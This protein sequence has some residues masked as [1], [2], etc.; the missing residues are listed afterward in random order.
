MQKLRLRAWLMALVLGLLAATHSG[1]AQIENQA[2]SSLRVLVLDPAG[3]TI[4]GAQ[5][6]LIQGR[7][8][9]GTLSTNQLGE[10]VF[11]RLKPAQ[12]RVYVE[13]DGFEPREVLQVR[14]RSGANQIEVRLDVK[15]IKDDVEVAIDKREALTDPGLIGFTN[16]LT[17]EQIALLP[18]DPEEFEA[19]LR[20]MAGPGATFRV[21]GF[22]GGRLP[23]K[24]QI[25]EIRF[26]LN[27]YT[28]ENHEP[29]LIS[30]DIFTKPGMDLWH[31]SLSI[32]SMPAM[33]S[34]PSEDRSNIVGSA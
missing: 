26:Q 4:P 27:P 16:V 13:A 14:P 2:E 19:A 33:L 3:A 12:Y 31:G 1:L 29:G 23:P 8:E 18:D 17:E 34:P 21:N 32:G 11:A 10:T 28:A 6:R 20:Q 22:R 9:V 30:V 25:R 5:V 15:P 7:R 24:S